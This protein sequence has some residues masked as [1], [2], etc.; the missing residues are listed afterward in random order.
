MSPVSSKNIFNNSIKLTTSKSSTLFL[1]CLFAFTYFQFHAQNNLV[2]NYTGAAQTFTVPCGVT[3]IQVKAWGAGG[4]GGG[5]DTYSGAIGGGGAYVTTTVAVTPGQVL[6]I[7][8]GGGALGGGAC[9]ANSPGG[10]GGW[11]NGIIAGARGGNSG[12]QGCSGGGGGGGGGTGIFLGTT[13]IVV[14]GGG[15]GGSGGGNTSSGAAGGGGGQNGFAVSGC[16]P[17]VTGANGNG[18]GTA[19]GDRGNAD[20]AGGGG[21]GGGYRGGTGGSPPPGCDCGGCGGGGGSSYSNGTGTIISNGSGSTPGNSTDPLL[22]SGIARGGISSVQGGNGYLV[23]TYFGGDVFAQFTA[24]NTCSGSTALL[25]NSST[26]QGA[27]ISGYTWDF[28]DGSPTSSASNPNYIYTVAGTY[29]V[30]LTV[31]NGFGCTN[32]ITHPI[33]INQTPNASYILDVPCRNPTDAVILVNNSTFANAATDVSTWI[34]S[35]N[36][37]T[38]STNFSHV[39]A[40]SGTFSVK[41][42]VTSTFGCIDSITQNV[43][44]FY[45]PVMQAQLSNKCFGESMTLISNSSI[46]TNEPLTNNWTVNQTT[47]LTGSPVNYIYT[48]PGVVDVTLVTTTQNGCSDSLTQQLIV[49]PK[50]IASFTFVEKCIDV[51]VPFTNSSTVFSNQNSYQWLYNSNVVSTSSNYSNVF[52]TSGNNSIT[53]ISSDVYPTI[54]CSDTVTNTFF[55][56]DVPLTQFSGD[57]T[58]CAGDNILFTNGTTVQTNETINYSWSVNA[59][60]VATT[61]NFQSTAIQA[62][63]YQVALTATTPFGCSDISNQNLYI[64]AIPAPPVLSATTPNCIADDITLSASAEPASSIVWS[65]PLNYNSINFTNTFPFYVNQMG[66]YSAFI[67]SQYGCIS[68][69]NNVNTTITNIYSFGDF[70][71]PNVITPNNDQINDE[72][73]LI[74]YFRTCDDYTI[75]IFNRWGNLVFEQNQDATVSFN[76]TAQS[77]ENLPEGVYYYKLVFFSGGDLKEGTKSGFIHIVR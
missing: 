50:P 77:G 20:G 11:G 66:T 43:N 5:I 48:Q 10:A 19:G 37:T 8:V 57:T 27:P 54:T 12:L 73:N 70:E 38:T 2:Y 63:I 72:L 52:S 65:G 68:P 24:T 22:P 15:G 58:L 30:S 41:L 31:T 7:I 1:I 3:S 75:S 69:I 55:V 45:K 35:D 13:P 51:A 46:I 9:L 67:T 42:T 76:G 32:T 56:H 62:G 4:S 17:G 49:Y 40:S 29:T 26:F 61:T 28:G 74:D 53:L 25:S 36:F 16:T 18:N 64:Y 21:G 33:T 59:N 71:F 47:N 14:A 44:V 39:F 6:T 23:I 60:Q 34:A